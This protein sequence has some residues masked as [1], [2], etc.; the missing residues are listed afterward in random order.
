MHQGVALPISDIRP[1][2]NIESEIFPPELTRDAQTKEVFTP[3]NHNQMKFMSQ[4]EQMPY[5]EEEQNFF[6]T[7]DVHG[8]PQEPIEEENESDQ[9]DLTSAKKVSNLLLI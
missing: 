1:D 3:P 4:Q 6:I 2:D 9:N 7:E 5:Q 8:V